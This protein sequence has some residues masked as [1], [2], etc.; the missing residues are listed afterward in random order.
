MAKL[1]TID[2]TL[3][4]EVMQD[5]AGRYFGFRKLIEDDKMDLDQ[6]IKQYSFILEKR[7]SFD[8]IRIYI[9]L[10]DEELIRSF[11]DLANLDQRLFYDPYLVESPTIRKRVLEFQR[12]SGFTKA[13]RFKNYFFDCYENLVFHVELYRKRFLELVEE[14]SMITE[15]VK[16]FY[17]QNDINAIL[18]FLNRISKAENGGM[19]GGMETGI[20][21]GLDKKL[22]IETPMPIDQHLPIIP[23]L[24]HLAK[25]KGKLK[26]LI[27]RAYKGQTHEFLEMFSKKSTTSDHKEDL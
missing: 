26:K 14:Q 5:I 13:G 25:I 8:L 12:F 11:L 6:K 21:A 4:T 1:P 17:A 2:E 23:P 19:Q 22:Q 10:R 15:E 18:G 27:K 16:L 24:M 7:I 20:A 3:S 9:M